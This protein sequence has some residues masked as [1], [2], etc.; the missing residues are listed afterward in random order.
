MTSIIPSVLTQNYSDVIKKCN[1]IEHIFKFK[2][3]H[4]Y[5]SLLIY[6]I[7]AL[8]NTNRDYETDLKANRLFEIAIREFNERVFKSSV[9]QRILLLNQLEKKLEWINY[10]YSKFDNK[11]ANKI[12]SNLIISNHILNIISNDKELK[13]FLEKIIKYGNNSHQIARNISKKL[14]NNQAAVQFFSTPKSFINN[15]ERIY[16]AILY[17]KNSKVSLIKIGAQKEI[18]EILSVNGNN[19]KIVETIYFNKRNELN[20]KIWSQ[21][22]LENPTDLF[23]V[24]SGVINRINH[25]LLLEDIRVY[26]LSS[27]YHINSIKNSDINKKLNFS[28]FSA[29]SDKNDLD[30]VNNEINFIDSILKNE[31]AYEIGTIY[32][33]NLSN[34]SPVYWMHKDLEAIHVASHAIQKSK[35]IINTESAISIGKTFSATKIRLSEYALVNSLEPNQERIEVN[36]NIIASLDLNN[37]KLVILSACESAK[38]KFTDPYGSSGLTQAF[39][40]A[41]VDNIISTLWPIDDESSFQFMKYFYKEF[42]RSK[43]AYLSLKY[44]KEIMKK[45]DKSSPYYWGGFILI[46]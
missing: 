17:K 6:E 34:F 3:N 5:Q 42:S 26:N 33:L 16:N 24:S 43:D 2:E 4:N 21:I 35:E 12:A 10:S 41:G 39:K 32:N 27:L 46:N 13:L 9:G 8:S 40:I 20:E 7:T 36:G 30:F 11:Y 22:N 28:F 15:Q 38:G 1:S 14:K 44:A 29:K 45:T 31:S 25:E 19:Q 37:I 23:I 18:S